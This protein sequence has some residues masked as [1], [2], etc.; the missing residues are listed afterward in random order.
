MSFI[1]DVRVKSRSVP[2]E[3]STF[4]VSDKRKARPGQA[5]PLKRVALLQ[6]EE[7]QQEQQQELID[8]DGDVGEP[9]GGSSRQ[10]AV[11]SRQQAGTSWGER[12][13]RENAA[14]NDQM[15]TMRRDVQTS[16]Q[17]RAELSKVTFMRSWERDTCLCV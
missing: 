6:H 7:Q 15:P 10:Q 17:L 16:V 4:P 13:A 8:D 2:I 9:E 5:P 1:P 11:G 3:P 14:W 12:M